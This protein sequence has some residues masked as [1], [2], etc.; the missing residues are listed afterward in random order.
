MADERELRREI[1]RER[2]ELS[3]AVGSLRAELH[4]AKRRAPAMAAGGIAL[5]S[6]LRI[7]LRRLRRR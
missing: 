2:E 1:A 5:V 6:A 3:G 7:G 4:R